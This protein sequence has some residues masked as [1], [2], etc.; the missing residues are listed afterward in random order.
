MNNCYNES[1]VKNIIA[2]KEKA[3][4]QGLKAD[5]GTNNNVFDSIK[6][7]NAKESKTEHKSLTKKSELNKQNPD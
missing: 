1:Q 2:E 5:N 4:Q 7:T 3:A 6:K